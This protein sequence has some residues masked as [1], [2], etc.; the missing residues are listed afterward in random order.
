MTINNLTPYEA[1]RIGVFVCDC[2]SN[3]A[4]HLDCT[5]VAEYAKT[6]VLFRILLHAFHQGGHYC[7]R[8]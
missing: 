5:D 2:G 1:P 6:S 4:G 7:P 8:T 3:I